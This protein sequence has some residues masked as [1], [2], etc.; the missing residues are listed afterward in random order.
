MTLQTASDFTK[1]GVARY[2]AAIVDAFVRKPDQRHEYHLFLLPTL[3]PPEAWLKAPNVRIHRTWRRYS[4]WNMLMGGFEARRHGIDF[5]FS[6]AHTVP[7][8]SSVPKGMMVHDLFP[9]H[10][11][12]MY[13]PNQLA[14]YKR[15]IPRSCR[16]CRVL[17]ANSEDTK[18]DVVETIGISPEKIIVTPLGPGNIIERRDPTSVGDEELA[19]ALGLPAGTRPGRYVLT[20]STLEPRKNLTGLIRGFALL[21][22]DPEFADLTL[23]VAG[24]KGWMYDDV[25]EV[26]RQLG[27]EEAV[28][29]LG[30]VPDADLPALF[31][32]CETYVCA[33]I[34]EGFGMPVLE[35]MIAGA[36]VVA[37]NGGA[38]P[39]V[40]GDLA[41]YF[42]P[43][44]PEDIAR[45]LREQL[46]ATD[47]AERVAKGFERAEQFTWD[48]CAEL[49][50][51]GIERA[52][53][54]A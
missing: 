25:F 5:W 8:L 30:Y 35:A 47:R 12:E 37:S 29:F 22:T 33:S 36:P 32:R 4:K 7:M 45:A 16:A 3:E 26:V 48:R 15:I 38:I 23:A 34:T 27:L 39:E 11:P 51:E 43:K 24:G 18:R 44:S 2:T 17:F 20:L 19:R 31:A 41:R 49:T 14:F 42:D 10:Y 6:T 50:L 13:L 46:K 40:G 52:V 53:K 9:L 1:A 28:L 21:R 54:G